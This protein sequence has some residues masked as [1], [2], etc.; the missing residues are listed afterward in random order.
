MAKYSFEFKLQ[1]VNDY[2]NGN[3]GYQYLA[4]KYGIPQ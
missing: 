1:V 3:G 2:L 4:Q